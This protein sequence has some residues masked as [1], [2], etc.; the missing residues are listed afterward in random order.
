MFA[1]FTVLR[2]DNLSF[3]GEEKSFAIKRQMGLKPEIFKRVL[4]R[5]IVKNLQ[6]KHTF[7][8]GIEMTVVRSREQKSGQK[9]S[10]DC[11]LFDAS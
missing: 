3:T 1:Y 4:L 8:E 9:K 10:W 2:E 11:S 7:K 5:Q 6:K